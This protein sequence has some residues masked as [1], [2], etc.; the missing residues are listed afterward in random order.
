MT[1]Y[2]GKEGTVVTFFSFLLHLGRERKRGSQE[3]EEVLS[4]FTEVKVRHLKPYLSRSAEV[5]V[6]TSK[7]QTHHEQVGAA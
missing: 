5:L 6:V 2:L 1:D 3:E 7:R 4:S